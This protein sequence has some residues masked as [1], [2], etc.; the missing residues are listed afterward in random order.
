MYQICPDEKC[1]SCMA[2]FSICPVHAIRIVQNSKGFYRP[3]VDQE[4]CIQCC[5]CQK[6]CPG[7]LPPTEIK[8]PMEVFACWSKDES[9]RERSSS[10][11]LFTHIARTV[12]NQGGVVFGG[13]F[14]DH[15]EVV[16]QGVD[17]EEQLG[18]LQGSKYVQS[19]I[20]NSLREVREFLNQGRNVLFAGVP[21]QVA[22]LQKF[23]DISGSDCSRLLL[24]DLVCHGSPSPFVYDQYLQ[25]QEKSFE[26]A[27]RS[28]SFRSKPKGW[29]NFGMEIRFENG[30][31]YFN[32]LLT[33]PY[34]V[35]FLKNYFLNDACYHCPFAKANRVG[36]L[37]IADFWG[38]EETE[39]FPDDDRGIT[40]GMIGSA[41]G[42]EVFHKI[43][44]EIIYSPKELNEA[45]MGNEGL[46]KPSFR[47]H[48][49]D[50]FWLDFQKLNFVEL[51]EKYFQ[52]RIRKISIEKK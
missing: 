18:R 11:G 52:P 38:Y 20:G 51:R 16:H 25:F 34:I 8:E 44:K 24:V 45:V 13:S 31:R 17:K 30:E 15:F 37:T 29:H 5:L 6:V 40:L 19:R 23:L 12:L 32:D 10:G 2:C 42:H 41:Q 27:I 49:Y 33:D 47:N 35:G 7:L 14:A 9:I 50:E 28:L 39:G 22:G 36:D 4:I 26:S 21:C 1:M 3:Q 43:K 46:K 48:R